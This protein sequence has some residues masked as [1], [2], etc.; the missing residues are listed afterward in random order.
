M[1]TLG[2]VVS[3]RQKRTQNVWL[4]LHETHRIVRFMETQSRTVVARG[5][6]RRKQ[7]ARVS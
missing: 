3:A 5:C 6:W 2:S 1:K 4:S 7:E